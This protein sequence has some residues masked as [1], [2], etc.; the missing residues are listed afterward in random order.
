MNDLQL[1][2][3]EHFGEIEADIYSTPKIVQAIRDILD[4]PEQDHGTQER[5]Q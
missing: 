2:K 4:L 1:I 5:V 3:S